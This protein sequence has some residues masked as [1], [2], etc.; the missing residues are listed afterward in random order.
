MATVAYAVLTVVILIGPMVFLAWAA[1][2]VR[3]RG[4]SGAGLMGV[5]DEIYNP[6]AHR[7]NQEM[8]VYDQRAAPTPAP[9]D[10]PLA[11]LDADPRPR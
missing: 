5:F 2:R 9:G 1:R 7:H 11:D 6:A 10:G 4:G 8:V 3:A